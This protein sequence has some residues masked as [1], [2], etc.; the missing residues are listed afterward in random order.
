M[1]NKTCLVGINFTLLWTY[2]PFYIFLDLSYKNFAC[3]YLHDLYLQSI[4]MLLLAE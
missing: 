4:F 1:L 2:S 3:L